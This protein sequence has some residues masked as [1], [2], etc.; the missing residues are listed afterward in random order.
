MQAINYHNL[1][2][3]VTYFIMPLKTTKHA[4]HKKCIVA[5][6]DM[7]GKQETS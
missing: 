7:R 4:P 3:P 6:A 5:S 2:F 1:P